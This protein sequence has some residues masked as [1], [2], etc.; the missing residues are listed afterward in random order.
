MV[1]SIKKCACIFFTNA[2]PIIV[3]GGSGAIGEG[4]DLLKLVE[5]SAN[6]AVGFQHLFPFDLSNGCAIMWKIHL[7]QEL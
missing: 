7:R 1:A 2:S 4:S 6:F 5:I 3:V